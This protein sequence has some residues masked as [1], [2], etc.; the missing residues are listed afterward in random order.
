MI[1][2]V[3]GAGQLIAEVFMYRCRPLQ[4]GKLLR[5][6]RETC[7]FQ[8][9]LGKCLGN[10]AFQL[11]KLFLLIRQA[12]LRHLAQLRLQLSALIHHVLLFAAQRIDLVNQAFNRL[13]LRNQPKQIQLR[14]LLL[15]LQD[16]F[17]DFQAAQVILQFFLYGTLHEKLG[18]QRLCLTVQYL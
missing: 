6:P 10:A 7:P 9:R 2:L 17:L 4:A 12:L 15:R 18:K 13:P 1:P 8:V 3:D 5:I 11:H 14:K 16:F